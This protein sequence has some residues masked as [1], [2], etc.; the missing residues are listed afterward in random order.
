MKSVTINATEREDL[1]SKFARKLRKEGNVPCVAY[2]AAEPLHFY[3]DTLQFR[4]L[5]YT[6][7]AR[8]AEI[9]VGDKKLDA[10]IQDIQFH[11]V[12]DEIMHID[13]MELTAGKAVT[14]EVPV[15][16]NGLSRGVRNGG[17][18]KHVFRKVSVRALPKDLPSE[19]N[20]DVTELRIG[21]GIRID[22]L[23]KD[24]DFEF[25]HP[26]NTVICSIR[27]SRGAVED[28]ESEDDEE[29]EGE[30]GAEA[31]AE[32]GDAAEAKAEE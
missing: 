17:V 16:L 31:A 15:I 18:M 7:E 19:I 32:G 4:D 12:S 21:Q 22:E 11:P 10:I 29:G 27:M 13:F 6:A 23:T 24:G 25:M 2:G 3:A 1:G 30:E 26:D 9:T 28:E 20:I 5:V 14:I 8:K